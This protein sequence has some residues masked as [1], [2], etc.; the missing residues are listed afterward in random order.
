MAVAIS[1]VTPDSAS[2]ILAPAWLVGT[3]LGVVGTQ[4]V[5][6][7]GYQLESH[8]GPALTAGQAALPLELFV[9][10]LVLRECEQQLLVAVAE[11]VEHQVELVAVP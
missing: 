1:P 2:R 4:G 3:L 8:V 11:Q 6:A 9:K 5:I 10:R 7:A